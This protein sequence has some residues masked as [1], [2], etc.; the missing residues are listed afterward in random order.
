[1]SFPT[2]TDVDNAVP[3]NGTPDRRLLNP[4]LKKLAGVAP[5]DVVVG[6]GDSI[7]EGLNKLP[8][9]GRML[10][11]GK[12]VLTT[13]I[14]LTGKN[15]DMLDMSAAT[16]EV[17]A[18]VT[19]IR[20]TTGWSSIVDL[21]A[22]YL[23][24]N[25]YISLASAI[26]EEARVR[27]RGFIVSDAI[28]PHNRNNGDNVEQYRVAEQFRI[29]S[30]DQANNR[31]TTEGA[32][33]Y[34]SI[35]E[36]LE[37]DD[38]GFSDADYHA[39]PQTRPYRTA[40][41]ARVFFPIAD[42]LNFKLPREMYYTGAAFEWR[43]PMIE[44]IGWDR[45]LIEG[46]SRLHDGIQQGLVAAG[47]YAPI[48]RDFVVEN[49]PDFSEIDDSGFDREGTTGPFGY[50]LSI[51]ACPSALVERISGGNTRHV[52]SENG[53][54]R[55]ENE[56]DCDLLAGTGRCPDVTVSACTGSG[57]FSSIL[58]THH[59]A[60]N[61][62]MVGTSSLGSKANGFGA[63]GRGLTFFQHKSAGD[64]V[65]MRIFTEFASGDGY[66][67]TSGS[68]WA[69]L[70][71]GTL[72]DCSIRSRL[73]SIAN[74]QAV[75]VVRGGELFNNS[76]QAIYSDIGRVVID[77]H[78]KITLTGEEVGQDL[79]ASIENS[80]VHLTDTDETGNLYSVILGLDE[81]PSLEI[82]SGSI[83]E[84]DATNVD[85]GSATDLCVFFI[86][87]DNR[88]YW[89]GGVRLKVSTDVA[90][91]FDANMLGRVYVG[92]AAWL[93]VTGAGASALDTEIVNNSIRLRRSP[94]GVFGGEMKLPLVDS[95]GTRIIVPFGGG[96]TAQ[97][98]VRIRAI[99]ARNAS[100][101]PHW[102]EFVIAGASGTSTE[103]AA[104]VAS[105]EISAGV[106][107]A[108]I[109]PDTAQDDGTTSDL[110]SLTPAGRLGLSY[111]VQGGIDNG[112][113]LYN[114]YG[115]DLTL[116]VEV[117]GAEDVFI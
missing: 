37:S 32:L 87:E 59:G 63:R 8:D 70:S 36:G 108:F 29:I 14:S 21:G 77:G 35:T 12:H 40:N 26:P 1:M 42:R 69:N 78:V 100:N 107:F 50:G 55:E 3:Q 102:C 4:L 22:D 91:L 72:T 39:R 86:G 66:A 20:L 75:I 13:G 111:K 73:H 58:D 110:E 93:E 88:F 41:N 94:T 46:P 54:A 47:C 84:I 101:E 114:N 90:R 109:S 28:Q 16:I 27:G 67:S 113:Q 116:I 19:G 57:Q 51:R 24:S 80:I 53:L 23:S 38:T 99:N 15:I 95:S 96:E 97:A 64:M 48:L 10:V 34:A 49:M 60:E 85:V 76:A 17:Q 2:A 82:T 83:L 30:L 11:T 33:R 92:D 104:L 103:Y 45:P 112:I 105:S 115:S 18:N 61:W 6:E 56:T 98:R 9:G 31:V 25:E 79:S 62:T 52:I 117:D 89:D 106:N 71:S 81:P 68:G 7:Q 65:G 44:L 74:D 5:W 43:A